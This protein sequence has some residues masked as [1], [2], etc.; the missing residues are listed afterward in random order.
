LYRLSGVLLHLGRQSTSGHY[1]AVVRENQP[2][3]CLYD[4]AVQAEANT[5][6]DAVCADTAAG[7]CD[8]TQDCWKICNDEQVW[9]NYLS[10]PPSLLIRILYP[11]LIWPNWLHY[12]LRNLKSS[13]QWIVSVAILGPV[14][15]HSGPWLAL[16]IVYQKTGISSRESVAPTL[17]RLGRDMVFRV[18]ATQF[19]L[20]KVNG[21]AQ[22][23]LSKSPR[24]SNSR[25]YTPTKVS[26]TPST[27][28]LAAQSESLVGDMMATTTAQP[29]DSLPSN[30]HVS[31]TAY[32][33]FYRRIAEQDE[34]DQGPVVCVP[35][36]EH[37]EAITKCKNAAYLEDLAT[38]RAEQ[39]AYKKLLLERSTMRAEILSQ[40]S[41]KPSPAVEL[42]SPSEKR[43]RRDEQSTTTTSTSLRH[44]P[45]STTNAA[46]SLEGQ[47]RLSD[48]CLVPTQWL[49]D[50]LK[51]PEKCPPQL[52]LPDHQ[53]VLLM[54]PSQNRFHSLN[55]CPHGHVP[56][57]T[58][59]STLRAISLDGLRSCLASIVAGRD[60]SS[61]KNSV[62][63]STSDV[64]QQS[65]RPCLECIQHRLAGN[66]FNLAC[67]NFNKELSRWKKA[68]AGGLWPLSKS[69]LAFCANDHAPEGNT[70][71][72]FYWVGSKS[73]NRWRTKA[74]AYFSAL[75]TPSSSRTVEG[76]VGASQPPT[77]D[78]NTDCLCRHGRLLVGGLGAGARSSQNTTPLR[79]L[80]HY[81][82]QRL[83]GLFPNYQLPTHP[84]EDATGLTTGLQPCPDCVAMRGDLVSRAQR[85]RELLPD[86]ALAAMTPASAS[87]V[88]AGASCVAHRDLRLLTSCP[89]SG[90]VS[91]RSQSKS[92]ADSD[93]A[94]GVLYLVPMDF[95]N[96]W[97]RFIRS[98]SLA[99]LPDELPSGLAADDALCEHDHLLMPWKELLD[100]DIL[101]P[102][103]ATEWNILH[104]AYSD[105]GAYND[106]SSAEDTVSSTNSSGVEEEEEEEYNG[107]STTTATALY[108]YPP[109]RLVLDSTSSLADPAFK[110]DLPD[111]YATVCPEC[112][113]LLQERRSMYV[114]AR[115]RVRL[116]PC[117]SE[118]AAEQTCCGAP[119][120]PS[121]VDLSADKSVAADSGSS[122]DI[123]PDTPLAEKAVPTGV[124]C[125][126]S[127]LRRSSRTRGARDD[128]VL[129]VDSSSKL[130]DIR[131]QMMKLID[132]AP[133]DQHLSLGGVEFTDYSRTLVQLGIQPDS[134]LYLWVDLPPA[135]SA[136]L[137]RSK[138]TGGAPNSSVSYSRTSEPVETGFKGTRLLNSWS[139]EVAVSNG[140]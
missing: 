75:H 119:Q 129:R 48:L 21:N 11:A 68:S 62:A 82:W 104:K 1:I 132:V 57:D 101:F 89:A 70:K 43:R 93:S 100:E 50:W 8:L 106:R 94:N 40:L 92:A 79:C 77:T 91:T 120:Q 135:D 107:T 45:S 122:S 90:I 53:P 58:A 38:K 138:K 87:T 64:V 131:V 10:V 63:I 36:P 24:D 2:A 39:A 71:N 23:T 86:L 35:V 28:P 127:A 7:S 83:T 99:T 118:T 110:V 18:P 137:E 42:S 30:V 31:T 139:P 20:S 134:L 34:P 61:V 49:S 69:A 12:R 25:N 96:A 84:V 81:L 14:A 4:S 32:M 27:A 109:F 105:T 26:P 22:S 5:N 114:S 117:P 130:Q 46:C 133:F 54:S 13:Q 76:Q 128:F 59:P 9:C 103:S 51:E 125:P 136:D 88:G 98:P 74:Q 29:V 72:S 123:P 140:S 121:F 66:L 108:D 95:I 85:E 111:S 124:E 52:L 37:L 41:L 80:P 17:T 47:V 116:I 65:L 102:L 6:E 73:L 15:C 3:S 113:P 78:F 97:R 67:A 56:P 60:Q 115:I 16:F 33:L 55:L 126:S 112:Y 44:V 19:D